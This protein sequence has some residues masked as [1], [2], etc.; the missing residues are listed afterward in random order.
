[1]RVRNTFT[2]VVS[3]VALALVLVTGCGGG[4]DNSSVTLPPLSSVSTTRSASTTGGSSTTASSTT[5]PPGTSA[6]ATTVARNDITRT[7]WLA[8]LRAT[9]GFS[10]DT[11]SPNTSTRQPYVNVAGAP[12]LNGY[13][14]LDSITYGDISGDVQRQST[15][16][17]QRGPAAVQRDR[18]SRHF[19]RHVVQ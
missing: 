11:T 9:S 8:A 16:G 12:T 13:A 18:P 1:M 17:L 14:V 7:D 3:F 19:R 2:T 5:R 4:D 10:V 15:G 6:V